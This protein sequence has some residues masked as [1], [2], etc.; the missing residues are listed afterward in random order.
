MAD[1]NLPASLRG[2]NVPIIGQSQPQ[3]DRFDRKYGG[4]HDRAGLARGDIQDSEILELEHLL[5]FFS[6]R[7]GQRRDYDAFQ[8]EIEDRFH[9]IGWAVDVIWAEY[10]ID[11]V[12]Q[13]GYQPLIEVVG[14]VDRTPFDHD[15]KVHEITR[16]LLE[17]PNQEKGEV[18]KANRGTFENHAKGHKH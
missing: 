1:P 8:R 11:G 18:L 17:L 12:K 7:S 9:A 16:N 10:A 2:A 6:Q 3:Q 13:E 15:R 14:R 5:D 4:V